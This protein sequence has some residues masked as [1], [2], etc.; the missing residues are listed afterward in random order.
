MI[1]YKNY[2]NFSVLNK[3]VILYS[4]ELDAG[5]N[6]IAEIDNKLHYLGGEYPTISTA[7]FVWQEFFGRDLSNEELHQTMVDNNLLSEA[8]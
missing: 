4:E 5:R 7:I 2:V 6:T 8:I 3:E 1:V